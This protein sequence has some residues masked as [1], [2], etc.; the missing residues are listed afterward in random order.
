MEKKHIYLKERGDVMYKPLN[1]ISWSMY[2]I[3]RKTDPQKAKEFK[4]KVLKEPRTY[5]ADGYEPFDRWKGEPVK[6]E[7]FRPYDENYNS[8]DCR[9]EIVTIMHRMTVREKRDFEREFWVHFRD[10][11]GD[12]RDCTGAPF[13]GWMKF[14]RCKDR[15]VIIHHVNYDL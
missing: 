7:Y 5:Y 3:L 10:P 4:T 8:Y 11:Y 2:A 9:T 13:T 15:T 6:W 14:L 12:A 1:R